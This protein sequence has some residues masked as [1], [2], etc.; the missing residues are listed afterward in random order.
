MSLVGRAR[1]W[2]TRLRFNDQRIGSV[3]ARGHLPWQ[4][5]GGTNL[6]SDRAAGLEYIDNWSPG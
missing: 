6:D 3:S 1:C 5:S 2:W 4:I